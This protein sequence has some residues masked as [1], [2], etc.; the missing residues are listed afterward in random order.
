MTKHALIRLS[1]SLIFVLA[2]FASIYMQLFIWLIKSILS[3]FELKIRCSFC[4]NC[5]SGVCQYDNSIR[6]VNG[7]GSPGINC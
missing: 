1:A 7:V 5:N 2:I 6:G 3:I 4:Y